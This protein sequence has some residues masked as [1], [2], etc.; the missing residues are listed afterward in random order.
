M[1]PELG[2]D[3]VVIIVAAVSTVLALLYARH[4]AV[5]RRNLKR[6]LTRRIRQARIR[7]NARNRFLT[8][9]GHDLRQPLQAAGM[10]AEALTQ[11]L[12]GTPHAPVV[13][14]LVQSLDST[15]GL[16]STL[17]D[18]TRLDLDQVQ[19][20]PAIIPLEP[21]MQTLF[22]QLEPRAQRKNLR[23]KLHTIDQPVISDPLLLERLIR[24]LLINAL[25]YTQQGGVLL[26][27][28]HRPNQIGIQVVD[29][30][31]GIPPDQLDAIFEDFIRLAPK[32]PD[33]NL[34]LGLGI[35]RRT[36]QLL[37]HALEVKSEPG[38]GSCFT[39]WVDRA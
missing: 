9:M 13:E 37:G 38:R 5:S 1:T 15:H 30:G 8:V 11:R 31:T 39:L 12:Q 32:S 4:Q 14:R 18:V 7:E 21:F 6:A 35:V 29:T 19:V 26:G 24:N 28:R 22:L 17:M 3:S 33:G 23:Y 36:A 27:C 16:L 34:G 25:T 10:F 20:K 2:L